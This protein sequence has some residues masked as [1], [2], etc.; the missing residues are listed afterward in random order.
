MQRAYMIPF[1]ASVSRTGLG[2][3]LALGRDA[4]AGWSAAVATDGSFVW[5]HPAK[6]IAAKAIPAARVNWRI[7]GA[8]FRR[9]Q[10]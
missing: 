3:G 1:S 8:T 6:A 7:M 9:E 2:V 5:V 4:G 10:L